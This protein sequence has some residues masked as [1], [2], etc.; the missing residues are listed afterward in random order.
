[1]LASDELVAANSLLDE[2][3]REQKSG[4]KAEIQ[5]IKMDN[6]ISGTSP[7]RSGSGSP[8]QSLN[9]QRKSSPE[10]RD[11]EIDEDI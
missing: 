2:L 7:S 6:D 10:D 9:K 1:M 8:D 11:D 3:S 5:G 4:F